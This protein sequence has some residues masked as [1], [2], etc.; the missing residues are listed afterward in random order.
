MTS[1]ERVRS[2]VQA[3]PSH[4][5][6]R[7][8]VLWAE[9]QT[10]SP[11]IF[12]LAVALNLISITCPT[13]HVARGFLADTHANWWSLIVGDS[14]SQ[15]TLA[16]NLGTQLLVDAGLAKLVAPDPTAEEALL[17]YLQVQPTQIY[18]YPEGQTLLANTAAGGNNYRSKLRGAFTEW[19]DCIDKTRVDAK[20]SELKVLHPRLSML[21][22]CTPR[23]LE[24]F[25]TLLDWEGGFIGRFFFATG[26]ITRTLTQRKVNPGLRTW[27]RDWLSAA[28]TKKSSD[29]GG[30]LTP[31]AQERW[32]V[33]VPAM[34]LRVDAVAPRI[35]PLLRRADLM[36]AKA[37]SLVARDLTARY[38]RDWPIDET[39]L[40]VGIAIA[41]MHI[42][43]AR[44]LGSNIAATHEQRELL[45]TFNAIPPGSEWVHRGVISLNAQLTSFKVKRYLETL[46][47]QARVELTE[48]AGQPY[49]RRHLGGTPRAWM[50]GYAPPGDPP[51]DMVT[52]PP[53]AEEGMSVLVHAPPDPD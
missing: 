21:V 8:Y 50:D 43:N 20:G 33:W 29:V 23:H 48:Q 15:K 13:S 18:I 37:S 44:V 2:L 41:E 27:L 1:D 38:E 34:R 42:E 32:D 40:N 25:T 10:A 3:L 45:A 53:A 35:A 46:V 16:I 11:L 22:G 19:Y 36:A 30:F 51:P 14:G 12:H 4:S 5:F 31:A 47:E 24:D 9:T 28:N 7:S 17:K 52:P 49:V 39:V 6:L 26:P